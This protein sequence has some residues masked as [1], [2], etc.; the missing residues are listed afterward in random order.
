[1]LAD[2]DQAT[3]HMRRHRLPA[4]RRTDGCARATGDPSG[5]IYAGAAI[6][7]PAHLRRRASRRRIRSTAISTRR[8][9]Q[10]GCSACC[11][12]RQLDH[13]RHARRHRAGRGGGRARRRPA[14]HERRAAPRVFSIPPGAP[15]LPTL[16]DA[17]LDG[18]LVPGF[19]RDGDPLALADVTIYVPTRRAARELRAIFVERAGR[20]LGDPADDPAARR[21]RRGRGAV[22]RRR[23]RRARRSTPPIDALDRLLLLAPLVRRW[24]Q[25]LPAHVAALFEEE[26]V[27]PAS[28]ADAIWLARDLAALMDEIE[29]EGAD[30]TRLA[31]LV[32]GRP[33]RAGGR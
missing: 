5:L 6:I 22:R 21:I 29:T 3:G 17:L 30:W 11:M 23:R 4:R 27:V 1:M 16:A 2:L 32:A 7:H 18:R 10:G 15:F 28:A 25:R 13:G 20:R 19:R 9:P 8:S 24:K 12:R 14:G 31:G 26:I 33:R